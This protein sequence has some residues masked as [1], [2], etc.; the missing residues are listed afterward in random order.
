MMD[1][2]P[3]FNRKKFFRFTGPPENWLTAIKFM[4]WGLEEKYRQRWKEI[5]TGDIFFIHSTGASSS[6]FKNAKSG[7]IG[8]GVVG[9]NFDIKD[10]YLWIHEYKDRINRW[11]LLVPLS[12]IYL[13]SDV[14]DPN[15]WEAPALSNSEKTKILIDALLRNYIPLSKITRFPQMGSFSAV[16]E[17]VV[18]QILYDQRPLYVYGGE[19]ADDILSSRPTKLEEIKDVS[20]TMR[21]ADTLKIFEKLKKR[22]I[23]ENRTIYTKD[24]ELLSRAENIHCTILQNL[25]NIFRKRG[26]KTMFNK[27]VDLFA[28]NED[29]SF[30]ME[31]KSTENRNFR[32]QMRKG[33]VQLYEYEYFEVRE[34]VRQQKMRFREDYKIIVPSQQP[35]DNNYIGFIN[36]LKIGVALVAEEKL[37]AVGKDFGF[38]EL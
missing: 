9:A 24:N 32:P 7:I 23:K 10:S 21:Y 36:E 37:T 4:T 26:F 29:R 2:T 3:S 31:V 22:I 18:E 17:V 8:L 12:E 38:T 13:F 14:P 20:E 15:T 27:Y 5:Q 1:F 28:Y 6:L 33:I 34:F 30:L 16:A 11:P 19:T 35:Q 25:I